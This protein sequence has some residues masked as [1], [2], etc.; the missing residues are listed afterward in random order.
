ME[1]KIKKAGERHIDTDDKM[2]RPQRQ[3]PELT[4]FL[5]KR[6]TIRTGI[7]SSVQHDVAQKAYARSLISDSVH[8]NVTGTLNRLTSDERTDIFL[9]ELEQRIRNDPIVLEYF[10]Q[11]LRQSDAAYYDVIIRIISKSKSTPCELIP[12][13]TAAIDNT[14]A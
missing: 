11:V 8:R 5:E 7:M 12:I 2:A 3:S 6:S 1:G 14:Q 13:T 9:D 10:V 4:V